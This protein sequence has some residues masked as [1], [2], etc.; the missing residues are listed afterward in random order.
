[1]NRTC[2]KLG[3]RLLYAKPYSPESTGKPERFNRVVD[4]FL[5]EAVLEKP[6]TLDKLNQLFWVWLDEC[7]QNKPHSAL[8]KNMSPETAYRSD[9]KSLR[10]LDSEIVANAF[11]HSEE[12]K[13][14]KSGCINFDGKKYEVG[15]NFIGC[16]VDVIYDPSDTSEL[17]VECEGHTPWTVKQLEIGEHTGKRP[18]LP[19]HLGQQPATSSRLLTAAAKRNQIRKNQQSP[20]ISYRSVRRGDEKNV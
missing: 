11:L 1:M 12:R 5:A 4:S 7:Y 17:T 6:Q 19:E 8:F 14:D 2:S 3:I 10:F 18:K 16:K 9:K 15:L 13:V 20:V